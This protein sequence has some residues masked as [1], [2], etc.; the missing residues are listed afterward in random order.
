MHYPILNDHGWKKLKKNVLSIVWDSD[1]NL[2]KISNNIKLWTAGC[3]CLKSNCSGNQ[4]GCRKQRKLCGP[5]CKC[6]QSCLNSNGPTM[7]PSGD[8]NIQQPNEK[9]Q[10]EHLYDSESDTDT[11]SDNMTFNDFFLEFENLGINLVELDESDLQTVITDFNT[12]V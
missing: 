11:D 6:G 7:L 1:E 5:G 10:V 2:E 9:T 8:A 12:H 4:C 3:G